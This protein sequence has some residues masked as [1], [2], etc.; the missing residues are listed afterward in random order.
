[1]PHYCFTE[2]F[3]WFLAGVFKAGAVCVPISEYNFKKDEKGR[4]LI[5][6]CIKYRFSRYA[7]SPESL[8]L[9]RALYNN[10]RGTGDKFALYWRTIAK[11]FA[12]NY[13]VMGFDPLNEPTTAVNNFPAMLSGIFGGNG[14]RDNLGKLFVK[15]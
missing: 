5:S 14:D 15:V 11:K 7:N 13:Y 8:T 12:N 10:E 9:F 4:P 2:W 3:D 6:E 1:M